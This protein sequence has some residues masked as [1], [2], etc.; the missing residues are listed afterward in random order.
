MQSKL[1][2]TICSKSKVRLEKV[3]TEVELH[4]V[5]NSLL[6]KKL[7]RNTKITCRVGKE[8]KKKNDSKKK[9]Q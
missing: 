5:A 1:K 7:N 2:I 6:L 8:A 4:Q 3:K 9:S